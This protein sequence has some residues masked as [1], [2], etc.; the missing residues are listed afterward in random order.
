MSQCDVH[1]FAGGCEVMYPNNTKAHEGVELI[2]VDTD[3]LTGPHAVELSLYMEIGSFTFVE[4][5]HRQV[6]WGAWSNC[7]GIGKTRIDSYANHI[8]S[9]T[10]GGQGETKGLRGCYPVVI[11]LEVAMKHTSGLCFA[12]SLR[13]QEVTSK[14]RA[15]QNVSE[16]GVNDIWV[17]DAAVLVPT[18]PYV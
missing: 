16:V 3:Q 6:C 8:F 4:E 11:F 5:V 10:R 7:K 18:A 15:A 14:S 17:W 13:A 12:A 9:L 1:G 2:K